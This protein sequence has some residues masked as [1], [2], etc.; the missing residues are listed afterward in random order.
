VTEFSFQSSIHESYLL[1]VRVLFSIRQCK[2]Q[3]VFLDMDGDVKEEEHKGVEEKKSNDGLEV[4]GVQL[5]LAEDGAVQQ[6]GGD[7]RMLVR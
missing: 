1:A 2:Q 3:H 7:S 5:G 4:R 6:V